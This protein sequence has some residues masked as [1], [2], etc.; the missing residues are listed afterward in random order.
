LFS[1]AD[2]AIGSAA[3]KAAFTPLPTLTTTCT[4]YDGTVKLV[5]TVE[6][7]CVGALTALFMGCQRAARIA[8]TTSAAPGTASRR[9]F[10][11]HRSS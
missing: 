10:C 2:G 11:T 9:K 5:G 1:A 7:V 3:S 4:A 8:E 6:G